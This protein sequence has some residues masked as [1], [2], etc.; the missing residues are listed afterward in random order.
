MLRS[1]QQPR[2]G[3]IFVAGQHIE[4]FFQVVNCDRIAR[5]YRDDLTKTGRGR[6]HD[7]LFTDIRKAL[8][9]N[10]LIELVNAETAKYR[11]IAFY[12]E[13]YYRA[14]FHLQSRNDFPDKTFAVVVSMFRTYHKIDH[15]KYESAFSQSS[16]SGSFESIG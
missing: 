4:L 12:R 11:A 1:N 9:G 10:V 2:N 5:N 3:T 13:N 7:L 14:F 16:Q 8:S 6:F 15:E